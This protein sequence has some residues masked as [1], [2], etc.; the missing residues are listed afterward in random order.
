M[1][2][3]REAGINFFTLKNVK[4]NMV[5]VENRSSCGLTF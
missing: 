3:G 5:E 2:D 1:R 4:G